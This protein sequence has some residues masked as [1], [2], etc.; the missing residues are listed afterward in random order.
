MLNLG[1]LVYD[2]TN[3]RPLI[4][5]GF[6]MVQNQK[7]AE[8]HS[9]VAFIFKDGTFLHLK[10]AEEAPF[11]YTSLNIDDKPFFGTFITNCKCEGHC[12]GFLDVE[13]TEVKA[14]A[15]EAIEDAEVLLSKHG[16]N[17]TKEKHNGKKYDRYHIGDPVTRKAASCQKE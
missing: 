7:T 13:D 14:W 8:C 9:E 3:K 5:A 2:Y 1:Q 16:V 6:A 15:K 17:I 4:F 11:K 10:K 12:F